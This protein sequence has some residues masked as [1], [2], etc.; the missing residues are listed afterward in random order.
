MDKGKGQYDIEYSQSSCFWGNEPGKF[1]IPITEITSAGSVLDLGAGEGK[2]SIY[3]AQKGFEITAIEVSKYAV[4]NF[5]RQINTLDVN[6]SKRIKLLQEDVLLYN[7]EQRFDV[8]IAYGLLHCLRSTDEVDNLLN[9]ISSWT[10][11]G[12]VVVVVCFNDSMGIPEVQSYL[13]PTLLPKGYLQDK[14]KGWE[15]L[16]QEDDIITETHPTSVIEH[17]HA[18]SRIIVRKLN[19]GSELS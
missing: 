5:R 11:L 14:F 19:D 12:G 3:L 10:K 18:V 7:T 6:T 1:V 16:R 2:N 15:V 17:Q 13:E 8:V 4:D 9:K